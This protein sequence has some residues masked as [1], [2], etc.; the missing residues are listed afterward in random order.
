MKK[1]SK[2]NQCPDCKGTGEHKQK[3][4]PTFMCHECKGTGEKQHFEMIFWSYD[5][6]PYM[7]ASRGFMQD[8]GTAYVPSYTFAVR[9]LKVLA[10]DEGKK[11]W[12]ALEDLQRTRNITMKALDDGWKAQLDTLAP[13]RHK[14]R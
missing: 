2:E 9:P 14:I 7:L 5:Q 8:D 11:L 12:A 10:L 3:N 4:G 6:F 13:W 1:V